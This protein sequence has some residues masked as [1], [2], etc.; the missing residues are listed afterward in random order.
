[1]KIAVPKEYHSG[2][3]RVPLIPGDVKTLVKKGAE[4]EIESGMGEPIGYHDADYSATGATVTTERKTLLSTADIILRI[5]QSPLQEIKWLK[6]GAL[7]I[8]Y[9][10]PFN[11]KE[12]LEAFVS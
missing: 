10:D 11:E 3:T 12:L 7:H 5:R 4:V 1:M 9:F 8:S 2:E 6:Q